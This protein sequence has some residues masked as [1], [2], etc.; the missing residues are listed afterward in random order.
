MG[1]A[2]FDELVRS[3]PLDRRRERVGAGE[4]QPIT[5]LDGHVD[6]A[7]DK[8]GAARE[9]HDPGRL[10]RRAD[11]NVVYPRLGQ[12][13]GA[14]RDVDLDRL[15]LSPGGAAKMQAYPPLGQRDLHDLVAQIGKIELC[16]VGQIERVGADP[17]LG[18]GLRI[19]GE[20]TARRHRQVDLGCRPFGIAGS[21]K[22][23]GAGDKADPAD[24]GG[25]RRLGEGR[26]RGEDD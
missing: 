4:E 5:G 17:K 6:A 26:N 11:R 3:G 18:A 21:V 2:P 16:I 19:G 8:P 20:P 9:D 15:V 24:P 23:K 10:I 14:A 1:P 25:R 12:P 22:R 7:A 13:N